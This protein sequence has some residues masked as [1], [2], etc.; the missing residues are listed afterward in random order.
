MLIHLLYEFVI[1]SVRFV[2]VVNSIHG[3]GEAKD[4]HTDSS[5]SERPSPSVSG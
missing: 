4:M 5:P 1:A 2:S 3:N